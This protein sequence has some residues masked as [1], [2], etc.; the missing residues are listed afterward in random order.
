MKDD[1]WSRIDLGTDKVLNCIVGNDQGEVVVAG[2]KGVA[3]ML[4]DEEWRKINMSSSTNIHGVWFS[5]SG[6]L[7]AA[8]GKFDNPVKYPGTIWQFDGEAWVELAAAEGDILYGIHG[9]SKGTIYAVGSVRDENKTMRPVAWK[10]EN[11][12]WTRTQFD[13]STGMLRG[14]KCLSSNKCY[15]FGDSI[16]FEL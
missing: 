11:G 10:G 13:K 4:K 15:A 14:V 8:S 12:T 3:R 2:E 9:N 16:F 1:N 6:E 7:F 5:P